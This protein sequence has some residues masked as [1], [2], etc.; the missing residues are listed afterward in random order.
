MEILEIVHINKSNDKEGTMK[1]FM[2]F[3]R[4]LIGLGFLFVGVFQILSIF[5]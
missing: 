5:L 4:I 1:K 2:K 3:I